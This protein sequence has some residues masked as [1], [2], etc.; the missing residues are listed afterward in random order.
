MPRPAG[1]HVTRLTCPRADRGEHGGRGVGKGSERP[2]ERDRSERVSQQGGGDG[3]AAEHRAVPRTVP[4]PVHG[5]A[6]PDEGPAEGT[7]ARTLHTV[8]SPFV[9]VGTNQEPRNT[10]PSVDK[11]AES[12]SFSAS[13]RFTPSPG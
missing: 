6:R 9:L 7:A 13:T 5:S 8:L 2:V 3:G 4:G 1:P 10:Q 11:R 12:V